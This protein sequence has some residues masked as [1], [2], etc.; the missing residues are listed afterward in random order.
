VGRNPLD[1]NTSLDPETLQLLRRA[2]DVV[3]E[4][5]ETKATMSVEDKRTRLASVILEVA[6]NG[7]QEITALEQMRSK[8]KRREHR[9]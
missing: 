5:T 1:G 3:W 6:T 2:F 7:E 8:N 4:I 9:I